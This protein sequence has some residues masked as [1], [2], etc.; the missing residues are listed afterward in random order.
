MRLTLPPNHFRGVLKPLALLSMLAL[1]V[2]AR[3]DPEDIVRDAIPQKWVEAFLPE[4]LP[5]LQYPP[6][7]NDLDK[8]EA[9]EFHGRYRQSLNTLGAANPKT[10]AELARAA[11]I[12]GQ[13]LAALGRTDEALAVLSAPPADADPRAQLLHAQ[14]LNDLYRSPEALAILQQHLAA[15]RDSMGGHYLLGLVNERLGDIPAA[16][17]AYAWFVDPPQNYL[18]K[19]TTGVGGPFD[20][21]QNV[22]WMGQALDR[23]ASLTEAYRNNANLDRTILGIFVKAYDEIDREFWPAHVAAGEYFMSH[24]QSK[25]AAEELAAALDANPGSVHALDLLGRLK[26]QGFDFDGVDA[27]VDAIHQVDEDSTTGDL[28]EARNLLLQRRPEDAGPVIQRVL[29]AQPRDIEALGL[30]AGT[31]ALQLEDQNTTRML[32]EVDKVNPHDATAYFEVAQQLAAMRQYPRAADNYKLAIA[33]APWWTAAQNGLGLLYTQSGDETSAHVVLNEAHQLDPFNLATT[34][35]LRLLDM[36]DGFARKESAHFVVI[37]DANTDPI[38]PEYFSDY[39]ESVQADIS[40]QFHYTPPLKTYV[41][42]FPTHAAFSVRT[43]GSSWIGT[44]GAS[45]GR[46]IALVA[47]RAGESTMGTFNWSQVLRH[48]YTHTVTLG[49]TDNRIQHWMT[50]GLAVN[51]EQAPMRWEW[52]PMLYDAVKQNQLFPLDKLTW[53]FIRPKR[54][55]DRQLAYAESYWVC[56]YVEETYGHETI[57]R[58]LNDCRDAMPQE[59]FFPKE[60][61]RTME[62]FQSEFFAWCGQ[63]IAKWGYDEKSSK[64]YQVLR[65]YAETL[66]QEKQY[67]ESAKVWEKILAIRPVDALPHQRLA[68]IYLSKEAYDPA[69]AIVQLQALEKVELKD[70]RYAKRIARLY[71]DLGKFDDEARYALRSVYID[72]YDLSAHELLAQADE[73]TGDEKGLEREHRVIDMLNKWKAAQEQSQDTSGADKPPAAN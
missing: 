48:E 8:A 18:E 57:L 24:D 71:R 12:R 46:V 20:D 45:T 61:G 1:A 13:S 7:F 60:T 15:H 65:D 5:P 14:L 55:I 6:Y 4:A 43:T 42:V 37:Y 64:T 17:K 33:R 10:P 38:I 32:A 9:Q 31:S 23:W 70:N 25:E 62:Q 68:G 22:T 28:L 51:E 72:P 58:M 59:Q 53:G 50:E 73:K 29:S 56:R 69:K 26:L 36:M 54:P 66:M 2:V 63:Q 11:R 35:Y 39:L 47:P 52:V 40:A 30:L 3:A 49:A 67:A 16:V 44:V 21:A 34:N 41:E 27:C 19:W